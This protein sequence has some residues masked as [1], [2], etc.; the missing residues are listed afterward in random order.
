MPRFPISQYRDFKHDDSSVSW[1]V[2]FYRYMKLGDLT[3][4]DKAIVDELLTCSDHRARNIAQGYMDY[5][6]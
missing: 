5:R 6:S 2:A 4:E 3:G 1:G